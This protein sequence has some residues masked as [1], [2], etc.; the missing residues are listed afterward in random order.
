MFVLKMV[1]IDLYNLNICV[2]GVFGLNVF[3]RK[4]ESK[5]IFLFYRG[6]GRVEDNIF[7]L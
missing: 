6:R 1:L 3:I 2:Y 5:V 4:F 7:E